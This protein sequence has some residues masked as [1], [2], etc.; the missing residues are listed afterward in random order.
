MC[1]ND[2]FLAH[3]RFLT[4]EEGGRRRAPRNPAVSQLALHHVQLSCHVVAVDDVGN[5]LDL[6]ELSLGKTFQVRVVVEHALH[7]TAELEGLGAHF[8][9]FE[10]PRRVASGLLACSGG[11]LEATP[12]GVDRFVRRSNR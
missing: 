12:D 8:E 3:V 2:S 1:P 11:G 6:G 7:Y 10:G 4:P 5:P 9:L